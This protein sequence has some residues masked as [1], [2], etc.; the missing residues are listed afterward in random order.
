MKKE[1]KQNFYSK[2]KL[3]SKASLQILK[4][5]EEVF[6]A[7]IRA[8]NLTKYF[9]SETNGDLKEGKELLWKF[10][11]FEERFPITSI[12]IKENKSISFVWD[13]QTIVTIE[14]EAFSNNS[15]IVKVNEDGKELN[16]ENLKWLISNV[17]GWANFLASMKA[18]IEYGIEL[19]RGAFEFL[20]HENN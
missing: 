11:E 16:E 2:M 8:E 12:K 5:V 19:R 9:I 15:T 17:A 13:P 14:L 4:S 20:R 18:Y 6:E 3:K 1:I 7:I 10:P